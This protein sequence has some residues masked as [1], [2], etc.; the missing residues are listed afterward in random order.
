MQF[1]LYVVLAE[2]LDRFRQ[3]D[4]PAVY[5]QPFFLQGIG[6]IHVGDRSEEASLFPGLAVEDQ[7]NTGDLVGQALGIAYDLRSLEL[8]ILELMCLGLEV[9]GRGRQGE[10]AGDQV[11]SGVS[12]LYIDSVALFPQGINVF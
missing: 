6:D 12:V 8:D 7:R 11:V 4:I 10:V 3:N 2:T 1:D 5:G 9:P